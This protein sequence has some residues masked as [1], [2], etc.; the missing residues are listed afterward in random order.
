MARN[1]GQTTSRL[2]GFSLLEL[3]LVTAI[4]VTLS[5]IA[6][7]RY[8]NADARYR[9]EATARRIV[10]DLGYARTKAIGTSQAKTVVFDLNANQI[11][12]PG[13]VSMDN[14]ANVYVTSLGDYP[15]RARLLGADFAGAP[16]VVFNIH[17][18]PN[19]A[20]Q[21]TIAV[22]SMQKT[23]TVDADTGKAAIQ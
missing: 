22:G 10:A 2:A 11:R 20:G 5:L 13:L 9:T 19:A 18:L 8:A 15:Y 4:L 1:R 21:I 23:V 6:V 7:P 14:A 16:Q 3:V 17:G 12:I